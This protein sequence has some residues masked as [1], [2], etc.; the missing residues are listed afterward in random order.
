M[1]DGTGCDNMTAVLVKL[2]PEF[3]KQQVADQATE[4]STEAGGSKRQATDDDQDE[5]QQSKKLKLD[6]E[7]K[8]EEVAASAEW[9]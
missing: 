9:R 7:E 4:E 6:S 2:K 3:G 1:G 8:A 5:P